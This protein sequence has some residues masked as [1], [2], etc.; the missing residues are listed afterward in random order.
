MALGKASAKKTIRPR[1]DRKKEGEGKGEEKEEEDKEEAEEEEEEE[2]PKCVRKLNAVF[3]VGP[4]GSNLP[5][6]VEHSR[7]CRSGISEVT[8][9]CPIFDFM[10]DV[11]ED[12]TTV[13][14]EFYGPDELKLSTFL[15]K[16]GLLDRPE[17]TPAR[18]AVPAATKIDPTAA[19]RRTGSRGGRRESTPTAPTRSKPAN[20]KKKPRV[21]EP[22]TGTVGDSVWGKLCKILEEMVELL[23]QRHGSRD[24]N[25]LVRPKGMDFPASV[26]K[27]DSAGCIECL[28][29]MNVHGLLPVAQVRYSPL[30][31]LVIVLACCLPSDLTHASHE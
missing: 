25:G 3:A 24:E 28:H 27:W 2:E 11:E 13:V 8:V 21:D 5:L 19:T 22:A 4:K 12:G 18:Q 1:P 26:L 31:S 29:L 14:K 23:T 10:Q 30:I 7:G 17:A 20:A 16:A 15:R 9:E 6:K